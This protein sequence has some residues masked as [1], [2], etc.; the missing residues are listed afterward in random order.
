MSDVFLSIHLSR[1]SSF[2]CRGLLLNLLFAQILAAT[3]ISP[4]MHSLCLEESGLNRSHPGFE[5]TGSAGSAICRYAYRLETP[6]FGVQRWRVGCC[7]GRCAAL[8]TCCPDSL[9]SV[10]HLKHCTAAKVLCLIW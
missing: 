3:A 2:E 10:W 1:R 4:W 6:A 9:N 7:E 8:K 5:G